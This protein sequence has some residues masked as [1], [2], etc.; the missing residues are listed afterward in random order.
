L[1]LVAFELFSYAVLTIFVVVLLAKVLSWASMPLHLRWELYP[2]AH[3]PNTYG[4]SYMEELDW[5]TKKRKTTT[6][7]MLKEL[8]LEMLFIRRLFT[9]KRTLWYTSF[10][11][12]AGIYLILAWFGLL[13]ISAAM[14]FHSWL[15]IPSVGPLAQTLYYLT[16]ISGSIGMI[17]TTAGGAGVGI[18]RVTD[19]EMRQYSAASDYFN[20]VFVVAATALGLVSWV[21]YDPTFGTA[22]QFMAALISFGQIGMPQLSTLVQ[23][24][25][26]VVG[27]L[28]MYLPFTKMTHFV[29]KYFTYHAVLWDDAPNLRGSKIEQKVKENL[30]YRIS[31]SG[32]HL[33]AGRTWA[34]DATQPISSRSKTKR[35]T[36]D[37]Q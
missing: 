18:E 33:N 12:H 17:A 2:V 19:R 28:F 24:Q 30:G 15:V 20:L 27:L 25:I 9:H 23:V 32:P 11:F 14:V 5:W 29:G 16:L 1:S 7:G 3:E 26:V 37:Q 35:E 4:G 34:E 10:A 36:N 22:R 21:L 6:V 13:F 8:L 31:W